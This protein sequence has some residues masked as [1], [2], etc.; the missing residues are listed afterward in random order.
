LLNVPI[1]FKKTMTLEELLKMPLHEIIELDY[2]TKVL[3]VVDGWV[4]LFNS[5]SC[6]VPEPR[7]KITIGGRNDDYVIDREPLIDPPLNDI[8]F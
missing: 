1:K 3:R 7:I 6:F 5:S 2:T 8:P 4:Y